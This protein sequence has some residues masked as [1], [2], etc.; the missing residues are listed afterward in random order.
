[1]LL[2]FTSAIYLVVPHRAPPHPPSLRKI[3]YH[4]F[5]CSFC[6]SALCFI[7]LH[8]GSPLSGAVFSVSRNRRR[9]L[10]PIRPHPAFSVSVLHNFA[11]RFFD[12]AVSCISSRHF[13]E[14]KDAR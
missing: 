7:S 4:D 10:H 5:L 8:D 6:R 14:Q 1:M 3:R 2:L 12:I 9:S 11:A 13:A